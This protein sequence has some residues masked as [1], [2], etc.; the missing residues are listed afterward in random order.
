MT[1]TNKKQEEIQAFTEL[2]KMAPLS[3][4]KKQAAISALPKMNDKEL[5]RLLSIISTQLLT[6]LEHDAYQEIEQTLREIANN[7]NKA[8]S[9]KEFSD[10][11]QKVWNGYLE[12]NIDTKDKGQIEGVRDALKKLQD[13]LEKISTYAHEASEDI[14][15]IPQ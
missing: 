6:H 13:K 14:R 7:P 4:E 5:L 3:E 10:A 9:K 15:N 11:V 1:D 8:Y 12:K 2:L